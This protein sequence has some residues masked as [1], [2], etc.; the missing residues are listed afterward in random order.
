MTRVYT[1][2]AVALMCLASGCVYVSAEESSGDDS[3]PAANS[4]PR[5][6]ADVLGA[7]FT[8]GE[9]ILV[10]ASN[11]SDP[12]GDPM[13]FEW[14]VVDADG[15]TVL[16]DGVPSGRAIEFIASGNAPYRVTLTV[17]DGINE[18]VVEKLTIEANN[19]PPMIS[20]SSCNQ[21]RDLVR[22]ESSGDSLVVELGSTQS[23]CLDASPTVDFED[24]SLSYQWVVSTTPEGA[25]NRVSDG[26]ELRLDLDQT[27]TW[28]GFL[29][30]S[31]EHGATSSLDWT[32]LVR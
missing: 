30:V 18:P 3:G 8:A 5:I 31:D 17:S 19:N 15:R 29:E 26:P 28:T 14:D 16:F 6:R 24:H 9:P 13:T 25:P 12:D 7:P 20:V 23:L 22:Y 4:P 27:G 11:T 10:D 21:F 1:I 32:V 2:A